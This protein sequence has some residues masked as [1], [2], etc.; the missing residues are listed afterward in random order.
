MK[1]KGRKKTIW[2]KI[3]DDEVLL[4]Q[5]ARRAVEQAKERGKRDEKESKS[6]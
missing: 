1:K 3:S 5:W 6:R 2:D 4:L